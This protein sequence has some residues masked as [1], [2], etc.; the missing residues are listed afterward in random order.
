MART[1]AASENHFF[2]S[3]SYECWCNTPRARADT[4]IIDL[5]SQSAIVPVGFEAMRRENSPKAAILLPKEG[6]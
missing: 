2:L 4:G 3:F 6:K 5:A 1:A